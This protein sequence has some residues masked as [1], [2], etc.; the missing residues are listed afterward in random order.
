MA[1]ST[2]YLRYVIRSMPQGNGW[3]ARA[4]SGDLAVG[5]I[6]SAPTEAAAIDAVRADLDAAATAQAAL[7]GDDGYP[8]AGEVREAYAVCE[9]KFNSTQRKMLRAHL[10]A[11]DHVLTA[12]DLALAVDR[13]THRF[14]NSQYAI[15]GHRLATELAWEP[16][17]HAGEPMWIYALAVAAD[18]DET[19]G[20]AGEDPTKSGD[21]RWQL[22]PEV[23]AA[24]T[25]G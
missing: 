8:T 21:R 5:A 22:R 10:E 24:M 19:A 7:R 12:T 13:T 2:A 11:P 14:A 6:R 25:K 15:L 17:Q 18:T 3:R 20:D 1:N 23:V 16:P 4:L 9:P